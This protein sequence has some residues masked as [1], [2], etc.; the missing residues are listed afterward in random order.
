MSTVVLSEFKRSV[1]SFFDELIEMFPNVGEFVMIRI[2]LKDQL[3]IISVM[4]HFIANVLPEKNTIKTRDDS[5]ILE[6]DIFFPKSRTLEFKGLRSVWSSLD[7][8]DKDTIWCWLDS[9]VFLCEKY[10]NAMK[11]EKCK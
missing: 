11:T 2:L 7:G 1:I 3:P 10:Q 4:N 5:I 9:F 6:K 8:E